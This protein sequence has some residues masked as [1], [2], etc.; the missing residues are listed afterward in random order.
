MIREWLRRRY[1]M[2]PEEIERSK[3]ELEEA[4]AMEAKAVELRVESRKVGDALRAIQ[5]ENHFGQ[6]LLHAYRKA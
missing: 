5:H 3:R 6:S 1:G 2:T 4:R